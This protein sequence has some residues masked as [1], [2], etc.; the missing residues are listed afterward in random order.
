MA[1]EGD[2]RNCFLLAKEVFL[3]GKV[4]GVVFAGG[5]GKIGI[6][7][8]EGDAADGRGTLVNVIL[9]AELLVVKEF[10]VCS[11]RRR[12]HWR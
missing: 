6:V 7:V 10:L 11:R 2:G 8:G 1:I 3:L 9:L 12:C 4:V 5:G